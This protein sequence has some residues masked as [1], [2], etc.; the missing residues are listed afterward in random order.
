MSVPSYLQPFYGA[1]IRLVVCGYV[2]PE[3]N[4]TTLEALATRIHQ[5]GDVSRAALQQAPLK[6][7]AGDTFL[8][9][10]NNLN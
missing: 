2:R 9:P 10:A 1:E 6:K 7:F 3:A 5:D 8:L 4:F